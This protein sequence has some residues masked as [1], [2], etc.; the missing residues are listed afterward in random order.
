MY[1]NAYRPYQGKKFTQVL[2]PLRDS[3]RNSIAHLDFER[4]PFGVDTHDDVVA[5]E[6][7]LPILRY[8][9]RILLSSEL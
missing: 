8:M 3:L 9:A 4:D 2:E 7:A 6:Q 5:A 1:A